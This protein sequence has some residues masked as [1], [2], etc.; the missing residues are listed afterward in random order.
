MTD[1]LQ[2]PEHDVEDALHRASCDECSALWLDL[3]RIGAEARQ[4]PLLTPSRDLWSGIEARI[5]APTASIAPATGRPRMPRAWSAAPVRLAMAASLLVAATA[6]IT[7]TLARQGFDG[8]TAPLPAARIAAAPDAPAAAPTEAG[9]AQLASFDNTVAGLD[10]EIVT[11]Q[12]L[13]NDRRTQLDP[14]T[15][16]VLEA[17]LALID[18]AIADSRA[19]LEADPASRFLAAQVARAYHRK[20]TLLQGAATLPAGT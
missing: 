18:R 15:I 11:L 8:T 6:G 1:R 20:L 19:A 16:A 4:L 17:N 3:E 13:V 12:A 2:T 10:R 7:W 9:I 5:A 14:R